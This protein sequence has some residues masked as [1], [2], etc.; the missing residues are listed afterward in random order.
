MSFI[1]AVTLYHTVVITIL[2]DE[3][4]DKGSNIKCKK[5]KRKGVCHKGWAKKNCQLTCD[6]CD[7]GPSGI[8]LPRSFV[9]PFCLYVFVIPY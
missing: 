8:Y 6:L 7:P 4:E 9:I 5:V 2:D 1:R 3:C